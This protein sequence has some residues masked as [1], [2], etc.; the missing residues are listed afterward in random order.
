MQTSYF[1]KQVKF[2]SLVKD[3][4]KSLESREY[5]KQGYNFDQYVIDQL[6]D[7]SIQPSMYMN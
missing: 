1:N 5:I 3:V 2:K 7:F 4:Q 6:E